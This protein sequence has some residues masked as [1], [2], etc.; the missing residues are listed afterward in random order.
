M[1][2]PWKLTAMAILWATVGL[3]GCQ[4]AVDSDSGDPE[5]WNLDE[6]IHTPEIEVAGRLSFG[7]IEPG[8]TAEETIVVANRGDSPL[9]LQGLEVEQPVSVVEPDIESKLPLTVAPEE[10]V[11]VTLRFEPGTNATGIFEG[12]LVIDSNDRNKPTVEVGWDG[13]VV[14]ACVRTSPEQTRDF[15]EVDVRYPTSRTVAVTNCDVQQSAEVI[16]EGIDGDDAFTLDVDDQHQVGE[17]VELGPGQSMEVDVGFAPTEEDT[18]GAQIGWSSNDPENPQ[19]TVELIGQGHVEPCVHPVIE[20]Q[21]DDGDSVSSDWSPVLNGQPQDTVLLDGAGS[22]D[23]DDEPVT[24]VAWSLVER[25]QGSS[26]VFEH[27]ADSIENELHLDVAGDYVVEL[28]AADAD[29]DWACEPARMIIQAHI[30]SDIH[31]QLTW[32]TPGDPHRHNDH[33]TDMD[34]HFLHPQGDWNDIPWDCHWQNQQPQWND[35]DNVDGNPILDG[36]VIDGWGPENVYLDDPDPDVEYAVGVSYF[37][38]HGYGP[39]E[40]SIEVFFDGVE[41][42]SIA[43]PPMDVSQFWEAVRVDGGM[44]EV[45]IVDEIHDEF[46]Q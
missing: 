29:G 12:T 8:S 42:I 10:S 33:G 36:D 6:G 19:P 15:G 43:S 39:S 25:P 23:A 20:A 40:A 9:R 30:A 34:L 22:I 44:E 1:T 31:V 28:D 46:P 11:E 14:S 16:L 2:D 7:R 26:A 17:Q 24:D 5:S 38:D 45:E 21:I 27:E 37:T 41:M 3:F 18:Y 35:D 32:D 4:D 13:E